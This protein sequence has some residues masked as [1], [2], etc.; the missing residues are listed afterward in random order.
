MQVCCVLQCIN[1]EEPY[2]NLNGKRE[3]SR[4]RSA[5]RETSRTAR[6]S[7]AP[8]ECK[9]NGR[10]FPDIRP[11][12]VPSPPPN[13]SNS[14][15]PGDRVTGAED[16]AL[17]L[18]AEAVWEFTRR[19]RYGKLPRRV[20]I[21]LPTARSMGAAGCKPHIGADGNNRR[22]HFREEH[23]R[24]RLGRLPKRLTVP[25]GGR[26]ADCFQGSFEGSGSPGKA[27][28]C[29]IGAQVGANLLYQAGVAF[30]TKAVGLSTTRNKPNKVSYLDAECSPRFHPSVPPR[31]S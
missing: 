30:L 29:W 21:A 12:P 7:S 23:G 24:T 4:Q 17:C 13:L 27:E 19:S 18:P 15:G 8:I 16:T 5:A 31:R 20:A 22:P 14:Q 9:D 25:A 11:H 3:A 2:G 28:G 6:E 1:T 26:P 10:E